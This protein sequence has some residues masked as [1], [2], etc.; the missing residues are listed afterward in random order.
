MSVHLHIDRLVV[1]GL[2]LV[3]ADGPRLAAALEAQLG[4]RLA[5][6]GSAGWTGLAVPALGPLAVAAAPGT[7][8]ETLGRQV[9]TAL[10]G[11]LKP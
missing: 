7:A 1:E 2:D 11:A 6:G 10:H 8:A 3:A 4:A 5:A 9:A